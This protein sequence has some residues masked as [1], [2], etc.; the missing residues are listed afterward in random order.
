MVIENTEIVKSIVY[1]CSCKE[2][3]RVILRL[4]VSDGKDNGAVHTETKGVA[5]SGA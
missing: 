2:S 1:L 3:P 5:Y 4:C